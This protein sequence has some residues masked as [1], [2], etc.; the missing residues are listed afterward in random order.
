MREL[1]AM[2]SAEFEAHVKALRANRSWAKHAG[3]RELVASVRVITERQDEFVDATLASDVLAAAAAE[4]VHWETDYA[5]ITGR[6]VS[7]SR[8]R[9]SHTTAAMSTEGRVAAADTDYEI[10][11]EELNING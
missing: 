6:D 4:R 9:L 8:A 11:R 1:R 10:T 7:D 3:L 5:L 2:E